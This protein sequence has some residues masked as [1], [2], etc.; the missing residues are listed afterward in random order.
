MSRKREIGCTTFV[1]EEVVCWGLF[2][3]IDVESIHTR[4]ANR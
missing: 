2:C 1:V 3:D 4:G